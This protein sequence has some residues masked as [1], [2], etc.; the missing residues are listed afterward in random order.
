[1]SLSGQKVSSVFDI[2]K[3]LRVCVPFRHHKIP[4]NENLLKI[5]NH[6][7]NVI[8]VPSIVREDKF[9]FFT[10]FSDKRHNDC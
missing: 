1:M 3:K 9:L 10:F 7:A 4:K 8:D 5:E 6:F 2:F